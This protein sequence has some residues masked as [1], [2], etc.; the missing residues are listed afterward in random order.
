MSKP[1]LLVTP[2]LDAPGRKAIEDRL[3][4]LA[5]IGYLDGLSGTERSAALKDCVA[6][7]VLNCRREL[8]EGDKARLGQLEF[9]QFLSA[10]VDHALFSR[11]PDGIP[12]A[13]NRGHKADIMA[14]H[15]L[16]MAL[17]LSRRLVQETR[18]MAEGRYKAHAAEVKALRGATC[19]ILGFGGAGRAAGRLFKGLGMRVLAVNRTGKS[20]D[21]AADFVGTLDD[22]EDVLAQSDVVLLTLALTT[23]TRGVIGRAALAAMKPDAILINLARADLID[24]GDLYAHLVA[25]PGFSAGLDVWWVTPFTHDEFRLDHPFLELPNLVATS[26]ISAQAR[27]DA[28]PNLAR[29][30]DNIRRF[31]TGEPVLD[32]V[33][34]DERLQ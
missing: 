31:L 23:R 32:R 6:L 5:Q 18:A 24:D 8:E 3:R 29:A 22:L 28:G 20:D 12:A 21:P 16:A 2:S 26:H 4:D 10:G 17:A 11:L 9:V 1:V 30:A 27:G 14:E 15:G 34:D 13:C 33:E 19:A 7:M 25:N